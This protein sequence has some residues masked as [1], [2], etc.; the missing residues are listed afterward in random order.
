VGNPHEFTMLELA[1]TVLELTGSAS[2]LVFEELPFDDPRQRQPDIT[3]ARAVLGWEPTV[4]L[5]EGLGRTIDH[6]R[7]TLDL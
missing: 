5:R 2:E 7:E 6:F 4:Q 1:E 3:Q